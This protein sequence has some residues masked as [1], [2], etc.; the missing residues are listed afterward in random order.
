MPLTLPDNSGQLFQSTLLVS[1]ISTWESLSNHL[2]SQTHPA[3]L[4]QGASDKP[5]AIA[6]VRRLQQFASQS[7]TGSHKLAIIPGIDRLKAETANALLKILEEPPEY[8]FLVALSE[9]DHILP[10]LRSRLRRLSFGEESATLSDKP[11]SDLE[12]WQQAF[13]TLDMSD[14][15]QRERAHQLLYLQSLAHSGIKSDL[16]IQPFITY[17]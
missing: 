5:M 17:P 10:T 14:P 1:P 11:A 8:L 3:D 2:I 13:A 4:W 16:L 12:D 7:A 15:V 9:S 6:E